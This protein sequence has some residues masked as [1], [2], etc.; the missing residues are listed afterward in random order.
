MR[1]RGF[2]PSA[3]ARGSPR[4]VVPRGPARALALPLTACGKPPGEAPATCCDQ[5]KFPA[6]VPAF[7]VVTDDSTG[8]TDGQD[9]RIRVALRQKTSRDDIYKS[10]QFLYRY[11]MTR[12]TF[13]P[14]TFTGLFFTTEGEAQAAANPL[15]KIWRDR[16][17]QGQKCEN[18]VALDFAEQV[19]KAFAYSLNRAEPEDL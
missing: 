12:R 9:V 18:A 7:T 3:R 6:G 19:D 5:L 2:R 16:S 13:Q 10:M 8:P 4:A 14:T 17:D 15:A 11:A 1:D